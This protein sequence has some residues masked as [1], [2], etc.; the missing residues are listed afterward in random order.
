MV[1]RGH[2]VT[3]ARSGLGNEYMGWRYLGQDRGVREWAVY[4]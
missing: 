4:I 2:G 3:E 1:V